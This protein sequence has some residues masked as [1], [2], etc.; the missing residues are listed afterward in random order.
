MVA[1]W[2]SPLIKRAEVGGS[3]PPRAIKMEDET[4]P[5]FLLDALVVFGLERQGH[6]TTI[7]KMLK[8]GAS[9]DKI[10]KEIGRYPKTVKEHYGWYVEERS[11]L[12]NENL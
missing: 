5:D 10:G 12:K 6:I 2:K 7:E 8:E 11:K 4:L 3:S 1:Q 9:W